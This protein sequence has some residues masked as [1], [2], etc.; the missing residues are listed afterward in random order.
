MNLRRR[1]RGVLCA[2]GAAAIV[3]VA[4]CGSGASSNRVQDGDLTVVRVVLPRAMELAGED[5]YLHAAEELGYAAENGITFEF[6]SAIGTAD[7]TRLV[8]TGQAEVT[9]P[10]PF[11]AI[12]ARATDLPIKSVFTTLQTN[13][14]GFGVTPGS[15]IDSVEDLRGKRIA[16]GDGGWTVIA[17]PLLA[18]SGLTEDDVEWVVAGERRQLAVDQGEVDAVLTWEMEYQNW[19]DQGVDV[20]FF[21]AD[22]VDFQANGLVVA[23]DLIEDDPELVEAI[24]R[25][26]AMGAAF[27]TENPEAAA[28]IALDTFEGVTPQT[29]EGM[30]DVVNALVTLLNGGLAEQEGYGHANI[31]TWD[32][33]IA[34]LAAEDVISSTFPAT[35]LVSNEF[36]DHANDFDRE[37]VAEEAR[38]YDYTSD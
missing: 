15:D 35:D 14:F 4:A 33:L 30:L 20:D 11:V 8:T 38:D 3:A 9:V 25:S 21:G 12:T 19:A 17:S 28:A 6:E 37:R 22:T 10:S 29:P 1:T 34:E 32:D 24:V 31:E 16:L 26:A 18:A 7:G 5:A 36:I 27:V 13:I 23:E 2:V